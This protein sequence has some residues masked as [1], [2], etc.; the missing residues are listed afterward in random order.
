MNTD[1]S[2]PPQPALLD[3]ALFDAVQT[4][5]TEQW[6]HRTVAR[7]KSAALLAGPSL[8]NNA[9]ARSTAPLGLKHSTGSPGGG[10]GATWT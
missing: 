4:K 3:S 8:R 9:P 5:L 7:T 6:S 2:P 1:V 10:A